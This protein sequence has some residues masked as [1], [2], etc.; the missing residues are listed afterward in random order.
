MSQRERSPSLPY[1]HNVTSPRERASFLL[2]HALVSRF[3]GRLL[4][5]AEG[6]LVYP[7][8]FSRLSRP[9]HRWARAATIAGIG[10]ASSWASGNWHPKYSPLHTRFLRSGKEQVRWALALLQVWEYNPCG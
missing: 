4:S 2:G 5:P 6:N 3:A 7:P 9:G 10:K 8:L 1:G